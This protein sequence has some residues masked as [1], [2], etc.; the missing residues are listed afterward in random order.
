MIKCSEISAVMKLC[1]YGHTFI[2]GIH[3]PDSEP[4]WMGF[5]KDVLLQ[6]KPNK[7]HNCTSERR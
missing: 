1:L 3:R 2:Q 4:K 6:A 5:Q 7:V